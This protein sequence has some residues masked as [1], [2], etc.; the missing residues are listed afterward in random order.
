MPLH[1]R[2]RECTLNRRRKSSL[3][4]RCGDRG[5]ADSDSMDPCLGAMEFMV[6]A[7]AGLVGRRSSRSS[8]QIPENEQE[9]QRLWYFDSLPSPED[10]ESGSDNAGGLAA[11]FVFRTL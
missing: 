7:E 9:P 6:T 10:H 2:R 11:A 3:L 5:K 1:V 4:V 8:S